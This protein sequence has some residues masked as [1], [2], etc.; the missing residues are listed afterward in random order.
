MDTADETD[1]T[2]ISRKNQCPPCLFVESVYA[3]PGKVVRP[4][5]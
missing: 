2:E 5:K 4:T 3:F 1:F